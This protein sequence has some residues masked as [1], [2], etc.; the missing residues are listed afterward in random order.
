MDCRE[1]GDV[2]CVFVSLLQAVWWFEWKADWGWDETTTMAQT[3]ALCTLAA[4]QV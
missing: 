3:A 4:F 2:V 1:E